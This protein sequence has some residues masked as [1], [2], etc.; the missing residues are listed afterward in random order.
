MSRGDPVN[1][2]ASPPAPTSKRR[3][4][5]GDRSAPHRRAGR[6]AGY[7]RRRGRWRGPNPSATAPAAPA[8]PER[9]G[10]GPRS[11]PPPD[12]GP[13][14][15][16]T[17]ATRGGA[18]RRPRRARS[19]RHGGCALQPVA[20]AADGDH[21]SRRPVVVAQLRDA[22]GRSPCRPTGCGRAGGRPAR[23][24]PAVRRGRRS[25]GRRRRGSGGGGP[26]ARQRFV[27]AVVEAHLFGREIDRARRQGENRRLG[28]PLRRPPQHRVTRAS[29]SRTLNGL[30]T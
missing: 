5:N 10:A 1:R 16:S 17:P 26:P 9:R 4:R 20:P 24:G 23:R 30:T 27:R 3:S 28:R 11:P 18:R 22:A 15:G 29:S 19:A 7:S 8:P 25:G 13:G 2:R 6:R 12:P 21:D 14:A